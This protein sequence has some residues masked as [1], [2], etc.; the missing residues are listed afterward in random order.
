LTTGSRTILNT[1]KSS[2]IGTL[3]CVRVIWG[4]WGLPPVA[5]EVAL[6]AERPV[7]APQ[8]VV[9]VLARLPL[10][11]LLAV[12]AVLSLLAV[13][14]DLALLRLPAPLELLALAV[15]ALLEVAAELAVEELQ[16]L[17][18]SFSAAMVGNLPSTGTPRYSPV[19]RSGRKAKRRP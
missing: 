13:V 16:A 4:A 5:A 10:L 15:L 1:V 11:S 19:P 2:R 17:H 14:V 18:R 9:A 3:P 12:L 7:L 8:E 6:E